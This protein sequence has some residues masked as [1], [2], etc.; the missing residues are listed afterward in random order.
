MSGDE[1]PSATLP[2]A[3]RRLILV[4][5]ACI[6]VG[7]S[8]PILANASNWPFD[9]WYLFVDAGQRILAG[10]SPYTSDPSGVSFRWSPIVAIFFALIASV[11]PW[12]W[13][14]FSLVSLALLKHSVWIVGFLLAWPFWRDVETGASFWYVP[15]AAL[16]V[17]RGSLAAGFAFGVLTVLVPR[18]MMLPIL[19]WLLWQRPQQRVLVLAGGASAVAASLVTGFGTDWVTYLLRVAGDSETAFTRISPRNFLGALWVLL[20]IV[21]IWLTLRGRLGLAALA[22]SPYWTP[23]YLLILI[24]DVVPWR[25]RATTPETSRGALPGED[26]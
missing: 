15:L 20:P 10:Q 14:A 24:L 21:G 2:T 8:L 18:P 17:L 22:V 16:L 25:D 23:A 11:G 19:G 13:T 26:S 9:D 5:A 12:V 4:V 6:S 1:S 7:I 3:W